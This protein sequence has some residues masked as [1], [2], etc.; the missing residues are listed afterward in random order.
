MKIVFSF[1]GGSL[2]DTVLSADTEHFVLGG[3]QALEYYRNCNRGEVGYRFDVV[4]QAGPE[5][6]EVLRRLES[7][8][9]LFIRAHHVA[10]AAY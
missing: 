3:D 4:H 8:A 6:Y 10:A 7:S 1:V 2:N 5:T 9:C